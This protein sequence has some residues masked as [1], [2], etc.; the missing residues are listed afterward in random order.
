MYKSFIKLAL[1]CELL[2][3]GGKE[4]ALAYIEKPLTIVIISVTHLVSVLVTVSSTPIYYIFACKARSLP[5][6]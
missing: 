6:G 2:L 1:G 4:N 5:I 3:G